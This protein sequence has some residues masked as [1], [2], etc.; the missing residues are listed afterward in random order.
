MA[1]SSQQL[2]LVGA[3]IFDGDK[4]LSDH[5]LILAGDHIIDLV[6]LANFAA[7][8]PVKRYDGGLLTPGF[9]DAQINGAGGV[10]FNEA[11]TVETLKVMM[12]AQGRFGTTAMLPTFITDKPEIRTHAIAAVRDAI[13]EGV[14]GIVGI[15][16][17]GPFL[18]PKR[19]GAHALDLIATMTEADVT[20][21]IDTG[22][23]TVLLTLAPERVAPELIT[24]LVAGGVIVSLGHTEARFDEAMTAVR[25]GARGVTHLYNAMSQL[26]HRE[27]G[28]VGAALASPELSAGIIAD[29][30]HVHP[31]ALKLAIAA[32]AG[33]GRIFLVTDAMPPSAGGGDSFE[34]NGRI[35][36]RSG[37]A[38]VLEDGT[39]AGSDLTMDKAL[40]YAVNE[41]GVDLCEA[42]RMASLY[43]AE[44]LG[45]DDARGRLKPGFR[46]DIVHLTDALDVGD[47]L[48]GGRAIG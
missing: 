44:F 33:T 7:D 23:R 29:G 17:E 42:L 5:A 40:R 3:R 13:E 28:M 48:I 1:H 45:L 14:P 18:S 34:L 16:L 37:N 8:I 19:K 39:L 21:L 24:Q 22:L 27:P 32:K 35:A 9:I 11:P 31:T 20:G 2:G 46:A 25:A 4:I 26:G 43:P 12:R 10:L 38:L 15:H 6:P 36:T 41:L 47:V 30:V